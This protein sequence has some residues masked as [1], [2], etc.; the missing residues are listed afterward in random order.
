MGARRPRPALRR[1]PPPARGYP[2]D[3]E[4]VEG[5]GASGGMRI[6][7]AVWSNLALVVGFQALV[8][9]VVGDGT[10]V[11]AEEGGDLGFRGVAGA[12]REFCAVGGVLAPAFAV[13]VAAGA[14]GDICAP[15][16]CR[17][18]RRSRGIRGISRRSPRRTRGRARACGWS[19]AAAVRPCR[20]RCGRRP[21]RHGRCGSARGGRGS[22]WCRWSSAQSR[23]Q[24]FHQGRPESAWA[25][26]RSVGV[27][28]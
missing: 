22:R 17:R 12:A 26:A 28:T 27:S 15:G 14:G 13:G 5:T 11:G 25:G 23:A 6:P 2:A 9:R 19:R 1:R 10:P 4:R 16:P 20:A 21:P 24:N 7:G 3:E 8:G 18:S